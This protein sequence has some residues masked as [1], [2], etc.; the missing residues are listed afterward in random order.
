MNYEDN[1][2]IKLKRLYS[3]D[4][5]VAALTR[6]NS[7]LQIKIGVLKDELDEIIELKRIIKRLQGEKKGL[8]NTIQVQKQRLAKVNEKLTQSR[9]K[10]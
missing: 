9:Y 2:L 3:K 1:V 8:E 10:L 4:E 7:E 6:Q 5:T